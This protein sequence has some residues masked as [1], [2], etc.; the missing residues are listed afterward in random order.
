MIALIR[1]DPSRF[2]AEEGKLRLVEK[3]LQRIEGRVL[4][5]S[6]YQV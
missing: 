1:N 3:M 2:E 5:G 6:I 4:D